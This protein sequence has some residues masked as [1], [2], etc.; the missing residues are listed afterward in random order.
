MRFE[1]SPAAA[2]VSCLS[3]AAVYVGVLY[4]CPT[5]IRSLPRDHPRHILARFLLIVVACVGFPF[6]LCVFID[7]K[8]DG[9]ITFANKLGFHA[10]MTETVVSTSLAVVLTMLLFAGAIVSN[11]LEVYIIMRHR[12]S[13]WT[14][15]FQE[16]QLYYNFTRDRLPTL[17]TLIF[18]PLTEEFAFRSCMLP[19][20]LDS[21]WSISTTIF[22]SP[23][24]FGVA[25]AHHLI[26]HIRSG[27][28]VRTAVAIVVFQFLYTTVFGI[29]ASFVFLRTGHFAAV[30]GVH[31]FCNLMGFPDLSFLSTDHPL[32]SYKPAILFVYVG[33]IV[34]FS[35][36]LFPLTGMYTSMYWS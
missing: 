35:A 21:G 24:A 29:F 6:F 5:E 14:A 19:L 27:R 18:G 3:M 26:D 33:G 30:F 10:N 7:E 23:L 8:H 28:P 4:C 12:Q 17:R 32:H 16:T 9:S 22:A 13:S 2:V 11:G 20:L 31:S 36:L 34:A 1:L 15:A 25:H